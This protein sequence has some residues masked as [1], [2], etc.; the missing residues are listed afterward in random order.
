MLEIMCNVR[1]GNKMTFELYLK[2]NRTCSTLNNTV[3]HFINQRTF[4]VYVLEY[5]PLSP[6]SFPFK[7]NHQTKSHISSR[8]TIMLSVKFSLGF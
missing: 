3:I 2:Y 5:N 8:L 4:S 7:W 6:N 1:I